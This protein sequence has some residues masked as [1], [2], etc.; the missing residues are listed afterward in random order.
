MLKSLFISICAK[1]DYFLLS[2]LSIF[3]LDVLACSSRLSLEGDVI[4]GREKRI[5]GAFI[6]YTMYVLRKE[7]MH[8]E[9]RLLPYFQ[10]LEESVVLLEP[11]T[12]R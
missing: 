1:I 10:V 2:L 11:Y 7:I 8:T 4:S 3:E 12:V 6:P 5:C 9:N